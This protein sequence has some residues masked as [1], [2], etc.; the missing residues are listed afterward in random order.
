MRRLTDA[1]VSTKMLDSLNDAL[2]IRHW[3]QPLSGSRP[4]RFTLV[5]EVQRIVSSIIWSPRSNASSMDKLTCGSRRYRDSATRSHPATR[6]EQGRGHGEAEPNLPKFYGF[7][8]E[9][10]QVGPT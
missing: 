9:L 6:R 10:N 5:G 7:G 4:T 3:E 1:C 8:G 2:R